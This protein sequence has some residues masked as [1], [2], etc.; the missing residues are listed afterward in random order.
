MRLRRLA[1]PALALSAA[2]SLASCRTGTATALA[3]DA[4]LAPVDSS[5]VEARAALERG[6]P[7]RASLIMSEALSDSTRRT[8]QALLVAAT[9]A[10]HWDGWTEVERL[11]GGAPWVDTLFQGQARVLLGQAALAR[12]ADSLAQGHAQA[13]VRSARGD[14]ALAERLVLLARAWDRL[15][16]RDSAAMAYERAARLLP[17]AADWLLLRAAGVTDDSLRRAE[18]LA[19]L[20]EPGARERAAATDASARQRAGDLA[21]AAAATLALGREVAALELTLAAA[22]AADSAGDTTGN[23]AA[24]TAARDSV[25]ARLLAIAAEKPGTPDARAAVALLDRALAPRAPLGAAEELVVARATRAGGP[26]ARAAT[27]YDRALAGGLGTVADREA[28]ADVLFRLARYED[29]A[30]QYALVPAGDRQ[31][32]AAAYARARSLVRAGQVTAGLE[33]LQAIDTVFAADTGA[34]GSA[35]YLRADLAVDAKDE[36]GARELFRRMAAR[37]PSNRLAPTSAFRAAIIAFALGAAGDTASMAAAAAELDSLVQRWPGSG[38]AL[39]ARYWGARASWTLGD[40][41]AAL[42]GWRTVLGREPL[43]YYAAA[44]A[45]RL[46]VEPWA[47]APAADSFAV[48]P[49]L[50]SVLARADLL[51]RLGLET[52]AGW[53][54]DAAARVAG[55]DSGAA[56]V[57]RLLAAADAF[58]SRGRASQSIQLARRALE[59]GAPRDA[60]TYRLIY[61]VVRPEALVH[62]ADERRLDPAFVA[63][64]IRQESM[65][66]PAATSGV[67]ARGLMQIMPEVG[68]GLAQAA[69]FPIWD[70]VLLYQ[71][72]VSLQLG[73]RHLEELARRYTRP[74]EV[75]AAYNAGASRVERWSERAGAA[76]AELFAERIPYVETRDYVR[77]IQRNRDLYRSLYDWP[78]ASLATVRRAPEAISP[79]GSH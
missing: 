17:P 12:R 58:R 30:R 5:V 6:Q 34:A 41:A 70:P 54:F 45:R 36:A 32:P 68:R 31:G 47:P 69:G 71:S 48:V 55:A 60:R 61:P 15:D 26:F 16:R 49:A 38:E 63:A 56:G 43:S 14:F 2:L 13:A 27:A 46:G 25:R 37:Y 62:E 18:L 4:V 22:G 35:L 1:V 40:S 10:S 74:V 20:V 57:E 51:V 53:E 33:L 21:G 39:A 29:A 66:N 78:A 73:T 59:R 28:Y 8:P 76:D 23:A 72:D 7:W 44:S 75:L 9:A 50:D 11:L 65:F 67:G 79:G 64:L 24:G 3:D 52:E 77:I 19:R 42:A